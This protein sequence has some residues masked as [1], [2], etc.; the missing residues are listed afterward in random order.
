MSPTSNNKK[1]ASSLHA[2]PKKTAPAPAK[3]KHPFYLQASLPFRIIRAGLHMSEAGDRLSD[4]L[5]ASGVAIGEREWR[6]LVILGEYGG[7]TNSQLVEVSRIDPST[8]SRAVKTLSE[9]GFVSTR[10]SKKDRRRFLIHLT[11]V[12]AKFHDRL[13]PRVQEKAALMASCLTE[14][15]RAD[16]FRIMDKIERHLGRMETEENDEWE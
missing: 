12:G 1:P 15:E 16:F 4:L 7:M 9:I 10:K 11:G 8:I 3:V 6:V 2:A 14:R 13:A 5:K